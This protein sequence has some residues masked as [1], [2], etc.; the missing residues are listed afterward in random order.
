MMAQVDSKEPTKKK[1]QYV[2]RSLGPSRCKGVSYTC[3][4]G[5]VGAHTGWLVKLHRLQGHT[6]T[7]APKQSHKTMLIRGSEQPKGAL[8]WGLRP[9]NNK[10]FHLCVKSNKPVVAAYGP[11]LRR[12]LKLSSIQ[13]TRKIN[14]IMDFH[15]HRRFRSE[16][17]Q[18]VCKLFASPVHTKLC[19]AN[20]Q[21]S[22]PDWTEKSLLRRNHAWLRA[23]T[24]CLSPVCP[25]ALIFPTLT[26]LTSLTLCCNPLPATGSLQPV[27]KDV[28]VVFICA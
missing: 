15:A 5:D 19:L 25:G 23:H 18:H 7:A 2:T 6:Y 26:S 8:L 3:L 21:S 9:W 1:A 4:T 17:W 13:H 16:E 14:P 27:S 10:W 24:R 20:S 22:L 12:V 28:S 11:V